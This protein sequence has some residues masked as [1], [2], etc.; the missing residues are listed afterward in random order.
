M[1]ENATCIVSGDSDLLELDPFRGIPIL[2]PVDFL[3]RVKK[4]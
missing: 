3:G 1:S 4:N 2:E